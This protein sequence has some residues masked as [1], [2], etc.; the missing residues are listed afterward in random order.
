MTALF[1]IEKIRNGSIVIDG[2]DISQISLNALRSKLS[3]IPQDPVMFAATLRYNLDPFGEHTDDQIW[4]VLES[5]Y[6]KDVVMNLKNK[7]DEVVKEGGTNFSVG[8]R[9]LICFAR[10][11]LKKPKILV[12]DEA[13]ASVDNQTDEKIQV[14]LRE[15]FKDCTVLTVA[16]RLNT[17]FDSDKILVVDEGIAAEFDSPT[18]L[19][20]NPTS[21]FR[22][23]WLTHTQSK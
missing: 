1:C 17:I 3:I 5:T 11:L 10:V 20:N 8:Q 22:K 19:L 16:H 12:L 18:N 23:M 15:M 2:V 9:Q 6:M 14:M 4:N 13:T 21:L 7:L